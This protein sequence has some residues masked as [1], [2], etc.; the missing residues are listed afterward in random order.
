MGRKTKAQ[1]Q[2]RITEN[3]SRAAP[4]R[5]WITAAIKWFK[6]SCTIHQEL[7]RFDFRSGDPQMLAALVDA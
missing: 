1:T 2:K 5:V 6:R 7:P 3:R 4:P